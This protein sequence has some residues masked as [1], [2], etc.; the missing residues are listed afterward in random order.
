MI[1][2][3]APATGRAIK[4]DG[5]IVNIADFW[6]ILAGAKAQPPVKVSVSAGISGTVTAAADKY[7]LFVV[8][9][10]SQVKFSWGTGIADASNGLPREYGDTFLVKATSPGLKYYAANASEFV[11]IILE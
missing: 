9:G 7:V 6:S 3:M 10:S 5:T 1:N 2:T 8:T 4:E 11:Y